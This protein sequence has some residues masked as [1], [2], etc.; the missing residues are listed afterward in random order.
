MSLFH[1]K[2]VKDNTLYHIKFLP[3]KKKVKNLEKKKKKPNPCTTVD[4]TFL[5]T[6]IFLMYDILGDIT[7]ELAN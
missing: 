6:L 1:D 4:N 7:T 5:F 3:K 2:K